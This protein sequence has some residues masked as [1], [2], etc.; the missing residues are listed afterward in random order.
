MHAQGLEVPGHMPQ[1]G[2]T[3]GWNT[4]L[5]GE[6]IVPEMWGV[7]KGNSEKG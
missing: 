2:I 6:S 4:G 5:G 7:I 1:H 3:T